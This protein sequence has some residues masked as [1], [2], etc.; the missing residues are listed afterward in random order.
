M[1]LL[2][3]LTGRA[4]KDVRCSGW[5]PEP[6]PDVITETVWAVTSLNHCPVRVVYVTLRALQ[7]PMA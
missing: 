5:S 3:R 4:L 1:D 6:R 7:P 2:P